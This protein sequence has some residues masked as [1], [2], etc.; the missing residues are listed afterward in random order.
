MRFAPLII[1]ALL[2]A[3]AH[4][5]L[6]DLGEPAAPDPALGSAA[7]DAASMLAAQAT[8]TDAGKLDEPRAALRLTIAAMFTAGDR[9]GEPGSAHILTARTMLAHLAQLDQLLADAAL[10][11]LAAAAFAADLRSLAAN[12]PDQPA[13]LDRQL[14]NRLSPLTDRF[15]PVEPWAGWL[16]TASTQ[17]NPDDSLAALRSLPNGAV[18]VE[19][20]ELLE[21]GLASTAFAR[22]A[23]VTLARLERASRIATTQPRWLAPKVAASLADRFTNAAASIT[24]PASSASAIET[25]DHL[26]LAADAIALADQL[27][28]GIAPKAVRTQLTQS[29]AAIPLPAPMLKGLGQAMR[30]ALATPDPSFESTLIRNLKPAWRA[31]NEALH[32]SQQDLIARL[33]AAAAQPDPLTDPSILAAM[34]AR[35]QTLAMV[36]HLRALNTLLADPNSKPS[37]PTPRKEFRKLADKLLVLGR[38]LDDEQA[39]PAART[40]LATLAG[41]AARLATLPGEDQLRAAVASIDDPAPMPLLGT[42]AGLVLSQ[43]DAAREEWLAEWTRVTPTSPPPS[44]SRLDAL[45]QL[46]TA[47]DDLRRASLAAHQGSPANAWPGWQ[48]APA[49]LRSEAARIEPALSRLVDTALAQRDDQLIAGLASPKAHSVLVALS[50]ELARQLETTRPPNQPGLPAGLD[51][52]ALGPPANDAQLANWRQ[53]LAA[54]CRY[55]DEW[56]SAAAGQDHQRTQQ[57]S[58]VINSRATRVLT[59]LQD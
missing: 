59:A 40:L 29:L 19:L 15:D 22:S 32:R 58:Q 6:L 48:L 16:R 49:I 43:I 28:L 9:L 41:D 20:I 34:G 53:E 42:R 37:R 50:A 25:L 54:V 23:Q 30:L 2:A 33:P 35:R 21:R 12:I 51:Q 5:Q 47:L 8:R 45:R 31:L 3:T 10:D 52:F 7:A 4:A 13:S 57:L 14:R 18:P 27:P 55:A 24:D 46:M 39:G 11:E 36:S 44:P 1:L 17:T 56:F 26:A 38:S